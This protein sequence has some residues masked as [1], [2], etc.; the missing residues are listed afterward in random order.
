MEDKT[1]A[2]IVKYH[3]EPK[4]RIEARL[5]KDRK[6]LEYQ[7]NMDDEVEWYDFD[8]K[9][10]TESL[11]QMRE[12]ALKMKENSN[13][14]AILYGYR[15]KDE[16]VELEP[17]EFAAEEEY[18]DRI[19]QITNSFT[20]LS[21]KDPRGNRYGH[22]HNITFYTIYPNKKQVSESTAINNNWK[23][24][25]SR[26][27]TKKID[28]IINDLISSFP[29]IGS[30]PATIFKRHYKE[31][32]VRYDIWLGYAGPGD[33]E[34]VEQKLLPSFEYLRDA[35]ALYGWKAFFEFSGY[36]GTDFF[37]QIRMPYETLENVAPIVTESTTI[38][39]DKWNIGSDKSKL[40]DEEIALL[41]ELAQ[42]LESSSVNGY[43]YVVQSTY[44]D[45]GAG[46]QWYTIVC[47]DKKGDSWQV[48]DTKEWLQLMN[49][50]DVDAV[51][52]EIVSGEY[53]QDKIIKESLAEMN[54]RQLMTYMDT[55]D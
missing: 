21:D 54:H 1:Y 16:E 14:F 49:T 10:F 44:E 25:K 55:L 13:A 6:D 43:K 34:A 20:K 9:Q 11:D 38:S 4:E 26:I 17:E 50:G 45:F 46:M 19:K 33:A 5:A 53:F 12:K 35:V 39:S 3:N 29:I 30:K 27:D 18:K 32:F 37:I 31:K 15:V 40:S 41:D 42:K 24:K 2:V 28:S 52:S 47:Y 7:L 23:V 22:E 51:Y 36:V 8:E 48:L